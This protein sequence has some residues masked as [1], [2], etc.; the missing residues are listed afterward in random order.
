MPVYLSRL[1]SVPFTPGG[2]PL[3]AK[4]IGP[5]PKVARVRF[6]VGFEDPAWCTRNHVI[7]VEEGTLTLEFEHETVNVETG[8]VI[9]LAG[10]VLH[11]A[12]NR[13]TVPTTLLI[14]SDLIEAP[15]SVHAR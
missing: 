15:D 5:D 2:H 14:V 10:E 13:G 6:D 9:R 12:S 3:E 4:K 7:L 8:E 11:R 1:A